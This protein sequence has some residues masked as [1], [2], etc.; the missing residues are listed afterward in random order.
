MA[1]ACKE[2]NNLT[3]AVAMTF[4]PRKNRE[5][6]VTIAAPPGLLTQSKGSGQLLGWNWQEN[7]WIHWWYIAGIWIWF[8]LILN[9]T[10]TE[11]S[12]KPL[13]AVVF[14]NGILSQTCFKLFSP[15]LY[16]KDWKSYFLLLFFSL[17][18]SSK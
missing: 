7:A 4:Q 16:N 5:R 14:A 17:L 15:L 8:F 10:H 13:K 3:F 2:N 1:A 18:P 11:N 9:F 12:N 6:I